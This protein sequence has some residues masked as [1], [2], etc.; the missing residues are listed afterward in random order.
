MTL[1]LGTVP[2]HCT[3]ALHR[4][5]APW[6]CIVALQNGWQMIAQVVLRRCIVHSS[7]A[8]TAWPLY[9]KRYPT[10]QFAFV[11]QVSSPAEVEI[12]KLG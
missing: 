5:H 12:E 4:A 9:I 2:W 8:A 3:L 10:K 1:H 11:L 7:R 6:P